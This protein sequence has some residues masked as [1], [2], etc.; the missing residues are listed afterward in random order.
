VPF[1]RS[2]KPDATTR[3]IIEQ[4]LEI[5]RHLLPANELILR[6]PSELTAGERELIG[7]YVSAKNSCTYCYGGHAAA[8]AAFGLDPALVDCNVD[9][10]SI[11]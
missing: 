9:I 7:T 1:L 11:I 4:R 3:D 2:L 8:A 5:F 10:R 6:G